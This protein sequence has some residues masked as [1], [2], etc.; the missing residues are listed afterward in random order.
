[1]L[2]FSKN[3]EDAQLSRR[4]ARARLLLILPGSISVSSPTSIPVGRS[5]FEDRLPPETRTQAPEKARGLALAA[6][7]RRSFLA[8]HAPSFD[9]RFAKGAPF[10]GALLARPACR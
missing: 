7:M 10:D 2:C 9:L 6:A 3:G 5:L 4:F 8:M 1:M